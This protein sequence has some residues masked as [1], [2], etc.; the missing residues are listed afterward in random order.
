MENKSPF[1]HPGTIHGKQ[2]PA[3]TEE[4]EWYCDSVRRYPKMC[5]CYNQCL[6]CAKETKDNKAFSLQDTKRS[7]K[8]W[9]ELYP[10]VVV[11]DPDGWNR[12]DYDNS[13]NEEITLAEYN[14]RL[15]FSTCM[16]KTV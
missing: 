10:D 9:Q 16:F 13:W 12:K 4:K 6:L 8:D 2:E 5:K 1:Y 7:S 14:K 11:L 15:A 3:K